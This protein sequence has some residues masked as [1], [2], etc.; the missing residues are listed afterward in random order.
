MRDKT[1]VLRRAFPVT[2]P[3]LAGYIFLGI[4]YGIA[5]RAHGFGALWSYSISTFIYAGSLQFAM[6]EPLR[7]AFAPLTF[8][9]LCLLIQARHLFY[10]LTMLEPYSRT[11]AVRPYLIFSL[12][13]ETY[14]I[15]CQ[16]APADI[17]PERWY[18]TVSALDHAYW[19]LGTLLGALLGSLIPMD[20]LRGIDF[21]MT[22]L[23]LVIVT[24]QTMDALTAWR[25]GK[26]SLFD[27]LFS[28]VL[29]GLTTLLSLLL[30]GK[31]SFLLIAMAAM[32]MGFSVKYAQERRENRA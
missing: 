28:P 5:M 18:L 1:H 10:G 16:G 23:F 31:D 20:L 21:S 2:V 7:S 26:E 27:A 15:V 17:L 6:I 3:V 13:D 4:A 12:T 19:V 9:F 8:A 29:G 22:A 11:G 14:S 32:I 30:F 24:E 25:S